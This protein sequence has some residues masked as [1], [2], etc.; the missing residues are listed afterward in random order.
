MSRPLSPRLGIRRSAEGTARSRRLFSMGVSLLYVFVG[1]GTSPTAAT[2]G[3]VACAIL[4]AI[5]VHVYAEVGNGVVGLPI[6]R[7]DPQRMDGPLGGGPLQPQQAL[8]L[9]LMTLP[10]MFG[11]L[12][13][14][15]GSRAVG[16]LVTAVVLIGAHNL[17]GKMVPVPF[18]ARVIQGAGW[19]FLVIAGAELAGDVTPATLWA[20]GV[21]VVYI[22]TV[23]GFHDAIRDAQNGPPP[24][25][26]ARG[27]V[28]QGTLA[29]LLVQFLASGMP[30]GSRLR[31]ALAAVST[32][33]LV[34]ASSVVLVRAYRRRSDPRQAVVLG[35][36]YLLLVP[37]AFLAAASWRLQP[38]AV[39]VMVACL[40]APPMLFG[41][42]VWSPAGALPAGAT[43]EEVRATGTLRRRL[44]AIWELTRLGTPATA[45]AL[46]AVGAMLGGV[47]GSKLLPAM[48]ATAFVVMAANLYNDRC[49]LVADEI[50]RPDRPIPAG[51]ITAS[52]SDRLVM[53]MALVIV[54]TSAIIDAGAAAA[55]SFLLVVGL[56]YSLVLRCIV[57]LGQITVAALFASPLLYGGWVASRG[58]N[59]EHWLA[60][61]LVVLYVFAREVLKGIPDRLGDIAAGYHT[62]ATELGVSGAL[63]VFRLAAAAFCTAA[64]VVFLVV[65]DAAYLVA[66]LVCAVVPMLRTVRLVRGSPSDDTVNAA[67]SFSGVVFALGVIPLLLLR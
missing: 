62:V 3:A 40:L 54:V 44:E 49:D 42:A 22:V 10:L 12:L 65:D 23:N 45:A 36:W 43:S 41:S 51:I 64:V 14:E 32:V 4:V 2:V 61:S 27:A 66:I 16:P 11:T 35:S 29:I 17:T 21:V 18:A 47:V 28:L 48:A 5:L 1:V 37:A 58:V 55:A 38:W 26:V 31:W 46:A 59:V 39:A 8:V 20:A 63:S 50:N 24:W 33:T 57:L 34:V 13:L 60:A 7:T 53:A 67:V 9:A 30:A 52:D 25:I 6:D 56:S 19:G 15:G